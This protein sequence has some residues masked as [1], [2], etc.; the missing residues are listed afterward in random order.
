MK[1][2]INK[3][4]LISVIAKYDIK[5]INKGEKYYLQRLRSRMM[6]YVYNT[7]SEFII[8]IRTNLE[9]PVMF[10]LLSEYRDDTIDE[11]LNF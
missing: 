3:K 7:K 8:S 5:D 10:K 6:F 1:E 2:P 11:I 4:P 9:L